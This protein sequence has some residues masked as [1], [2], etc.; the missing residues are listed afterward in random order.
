VNPQV[1]SSWRND[2]LSFA[3]NT[4]QEIAQILEDNYGLQILIQ[5]PL[6]RERKLTGEIPSTDEQTVLAVL[7]ETLNIQI[8]RDGRKVVLK[9]KE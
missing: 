4:V 2:T 5:D 3:D 1:Y 7:A 8:A 6:L 9:T